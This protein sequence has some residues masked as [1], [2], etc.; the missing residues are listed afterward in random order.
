[1]SGYKNAPDIKPQIGDEVKC[2]LPGSTAIVASIGEVPP[3]TDFR[4][5][6]CAVDGRLHLNSPG[7]AVLVKSVD[8]R[9]PA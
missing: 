5:V 4:I 1:M 2:G 6:N 9:V 8:G 3:Q 7:D